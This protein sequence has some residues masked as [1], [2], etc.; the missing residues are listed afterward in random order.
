LEAGADPVL[1]TTWMKETQ[2]KRA[3]AEARRKKPAG[4]R[5]M[6]QEEIMNLATELGIIM[7][8]LKDAEA[9]D[10]AEV[11]RRIGLSLTYHPQEK[12]VA[13]EARPN[14]IMYVG[15]CPRTK[16]YQLHMLARSP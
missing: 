13:A 16:A 15:A 11:Y 12:R 3:L 6:T 10:K 8:A 1:V 14:S 9:A 2:A 5:R 4:R 7:Q